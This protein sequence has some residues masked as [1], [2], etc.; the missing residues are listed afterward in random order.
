LLGRDYIS[1]SFAT[2]SSVIPAAWVFVDWEMVGVVFDWL[3][4]K[5]NN[6]K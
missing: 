3:Y 1:Y 5:I 4:N 6:K 2:I